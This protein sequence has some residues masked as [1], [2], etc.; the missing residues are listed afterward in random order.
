MTLDTTMLAAIGVLF[1]TVTG[2]IGWL[3]KALWSERSDAF[4]KLAAMLEKQY[5]AAGNRKDLFDNLGK[6]VD[7]LSQSVKDLQREVQGARSDI[8]RIRP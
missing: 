4:A 1:T 3:V 5:D 6:T 2:A 8:Q 7:G